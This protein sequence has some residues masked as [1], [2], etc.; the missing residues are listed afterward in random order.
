[1]DYPEA[2]A[3]ELFENRMKELRLLLRNFEKIKLDG[4]L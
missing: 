4:F 2:D 1:M 3:S